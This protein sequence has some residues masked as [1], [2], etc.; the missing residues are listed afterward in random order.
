[1]KQNKIPEELLKEFGYKKYD[2]P[3]FLHCDECWQKKVKLKDNHEYFINIQIWN[4]Q[5]NIGW[6]YEFDAQLYI[7]S[8]DDAFNVTTVQWARDQESD[9]DLL[10]RVDKFFY[11]MYL[12]SKV[13]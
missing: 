1:M 7:N 8:S 3:N 6:G 13:L 12:Y 10:E 11:N 2:V 9:R 4:F 5:E